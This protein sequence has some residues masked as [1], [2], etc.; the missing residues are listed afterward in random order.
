MQN[1]TQMGGGVDFLHPFIW[2]RCDFTMEQRV[3]ITFCVNFGRNVMET[4][5]ASIR[6]RNHELYTGI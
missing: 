1:L 2:S 4:D 5:Y 6:E 3:F